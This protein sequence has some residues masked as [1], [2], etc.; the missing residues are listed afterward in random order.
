MR[1]YS[2]NVLELMTV[3]MAT[4]MI[5]ERNQ[6]L[7][8][9]S[10]NSATVAAIR[11]GN[12]RVFHLSALAEMIWKRAASMNWSISVAHIGGTFNVLAD[13]LSR[14]EII[15]TEWS[16]PK[17]LFTELILIHE[18]SLQVDLFA[19]SLNHKL[20]KYVSPCPDINACAIDAMSI[21]W[22]RW[23]HIYLFPPSQL[24]LKV[25][26]KLKQSNIKTAIVVTRKSQVRLPWYF[27][28]T[29]LLTLKAT[30]KAR[31]QQKV[32][33]RLVREQKLST[34]HMWKFSK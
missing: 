12:S 17:Q 24:I 3:W 11:R 18:P 31:L 29:S 27:A 34:L 33:G 8:I 19:T 16:L 7:E 10:D 14:D 6:A 32:V 1:T 15:S 21:S 30:L 9:R 26:L 20:K 28:L 22:D 13:Q 5:Q 25:L 4:L 23:D 2:I